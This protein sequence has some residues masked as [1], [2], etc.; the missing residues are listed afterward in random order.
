M[1]YAWGAWLIFFARDKIPQYIEDP[2]LK[3]TTM[4]IKDSIIA[5][6]AG[7][8]LLYGINLASRPFLRKKFR[9][10]GKDA[11]SSSN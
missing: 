4:T 11:Q 2:T 8:V 7:A 5:G 10:H 3:G 1:L 6:F 9:E